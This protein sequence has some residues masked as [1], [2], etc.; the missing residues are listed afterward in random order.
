MSMVSCL[1]TYFLKIFEESLI[2]LMEYINPFFVISINSEIIFRSV[3]F[4]KSSDVT[5]RG[6]YE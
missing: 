6:E 2:L 4:K 5:K 3:F 1:G